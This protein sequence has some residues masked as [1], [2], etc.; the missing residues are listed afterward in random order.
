MNT[1]STTNNLFTS[2]EKIV[3]IG[4]VLIEEKERKREMEKEEQS[5]IAS[6]SFLCLL[7]FTGSIGSG[8]E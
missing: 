3:R 6:L 1:L 7:L 2:N 4:V 5:T 8:I